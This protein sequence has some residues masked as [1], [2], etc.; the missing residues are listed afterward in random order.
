MYHHG[1]NIAR[2]AKAA[3][4]KCPGK[5]SLNVMFSCLSRLSRLS[6]LSSLSSKPYVNDSVLY[7]DIER[8]G[9]LKNCYLHKIGMNSWFISTCISTWVIT[10]ICHNQWHLS[11]FKSEMKIVLFRLLTTAM[12]RHSCEVIWKDHYKD[13]GTLKG[14]VNPLHLPQLF[15]FQ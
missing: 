2:T 6:R 14:C 4:N 3:L 1:K 9:Q 15:A 11:F 7:V 13:L 8:L 5:S 12:K 10:L